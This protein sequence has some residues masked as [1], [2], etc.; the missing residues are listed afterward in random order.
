M[1]WAVSEMDYVTGSHSPSM[2]HLAP[3]AR[4][5]DALVKG[6]AGAPHAGQT[7]GSSPH[8]KDPQTRPRF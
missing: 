8:P 6:S 2:L 7:E 1:A 4:L 5:P 3:S